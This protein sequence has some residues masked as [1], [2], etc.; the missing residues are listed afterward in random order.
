M[1]FGPLNGEGGE[2][3][4][5]VLITRARMRCEVFT[6]LKAADIDLS[7]TQSRGVQAFKTFLAYAETGILN[8]SRASG[9]VLNA[10]FEESVSEALSLGGRQ[11]VP[12]VGTAGFR[13]DLAVLDPEQPGRYA[14]G[15]ECD[16]ENYAS[17]QSA[18]DR[19]R[20]RPQVLANLGW[21]LHRLWSVDWFHNPQAEQKRL[22]EILDGSKATHPA[23][24]AVHQAPVEREPARE[25]EG[26]TVLEDEWGL[27]AYTFSSLSIDLN[28]REFHEV[29]PKFVVDWVTQVVRDEGPVS[30]REVVRRVLDAAG[31]SRLGPRIQTTVEEAVT[32][33]VRQGTI[34]VQGDFLWP[35]GLQTPPLRFRGDLPAASRK[36]DL[37]APEELALAVERVVVD[38]IGMDP[39]AIPAAA[40]RLI[41]FNRLSEENRKRFED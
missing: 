40:G 2:R 13:M 5:N 38:A 10:P 9:E 23:E 33:A 27:P 18:R 16:G 36:L 37:I 17:A 15:I 8:A 30:S 31:K 26:E 12:R 3:R 20:L 39:E 24:P 34:A 28:G 25:S 7:R 6:N 19:D 4:L 35:A 29:D 14:L 11:V 1:N 21:N 32:R 41:G 22:A